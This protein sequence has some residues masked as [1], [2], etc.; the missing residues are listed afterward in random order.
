MSYLLLQGN[1]LLLSATPVARA[2]QDGL[3]IDRVADFFLQ[4]LQMSRSKLAS[5][6]AVRLHARDLLHFL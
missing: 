2:I 3:D 5:S 6:S 1:D 4:R